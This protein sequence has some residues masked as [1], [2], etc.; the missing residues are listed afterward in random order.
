[1]INEP[2]I[3]YTFKEVLE[4]LE[5]KIDALQ[6]AL[7]KDMEHLEGRVAALETFRS[8]FLPMSII[9][10]LVAVIGLLVDIYI[11]LN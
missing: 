5:G 9:V 7:D 1:M 2:K 6:A 4:R 3:E 11:R 10:G 8:R